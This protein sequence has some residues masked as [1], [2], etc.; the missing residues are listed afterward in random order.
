MRPAILPLICISYL[1]GSLYCL[2]QQTEK[3]KAPVKFSCL[4]WEGLPSEDLYYRE[5]KTFH[6]LTFKKASRSK[7]LDLR[8]MDFFELYRKVEKL[9]EGEPPYQLLAK[10]KIPESKQVLFLVT[11]F[12]RES[13]RYYRVFTM[14]D[15]L[16]AFPRGAFRFAN[17]YKQMLFVK[18]GKTV[19]KILPNQLTVVSS[20]NQPNGGFV[21]FL[22]ADDK[23][24][25]IFGTRIFGQPAGR[26]LVFISP[27]EQTGAV[28]RVKFV[29]QL[30]A[31][32]VPPNQKQN[33]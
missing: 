22:I 8:G 27:P 23:G 29:S 30:L 12:K 17:F 21:P 16:K 20:I 5:K 1:L 33:P 4:Y 28:P 9:E 11:P 31:P 7:H 10:A 13:A 6:K 26:E 19:K 25:K 15:S 18:C 14:D 2:G 24:K 3:E 32:P